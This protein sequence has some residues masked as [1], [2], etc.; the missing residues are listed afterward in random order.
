[1]TSRAEYMPDK[2]FRVRV[3]DLACLRTD[4]FTVMKLMSHE[5][6]FTCPDAE[7]ARCRRSCSA[8]GAWSVPEFA[9]SSSRCL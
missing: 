3:V 8:S 6:A 1:M 7:S 5:Y 4:C 2:Q 9:C